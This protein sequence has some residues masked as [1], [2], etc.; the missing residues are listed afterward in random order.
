MRKPIDPHEATVASPVRD[1]DLDVDF[2]RIAVAQE[3]KKRGL[4]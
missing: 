3:R 2:T 1:V 4:A